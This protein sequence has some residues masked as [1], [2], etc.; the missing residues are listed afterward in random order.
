[1]STQLLDCDVI[2]IGGGVV[3]LTLAALLAQVPE[4]RVKVFDRGRVP[5]DEEKSHYDRRVS[6]INHASITIFQS[7]GIWQD[8]VA[9]RSNPYQKIQVWDAN[10]SARIHFDCLDVGQAFLGHIVEHRVMQQVLW[11]HLSQLSQVQLVE[12]ASVTDLQP[13]VD[14]ISVC[15]ND[16]YY[17]ATLLIGADGGD[18]WVARQ[19]SFTIKTQPYQQSALVTTVALTDSHQHTAWQRFLT[20]GP[21]AFLPLADPHLASIVWSTTPDQA[22]YLEQEKEAAF[23]QALEDAIENTFGSLQAIDQRM[24]FPLIQRHAQRYVQSRIALVGDAAHTI[25]PLAGQGI[26]LGLMDAAYLAQIVQNTWLA[27]R[28]IGGLMNLRRYERSRKSDN[29]MMLA[30]MSGF[31]HVFGQQQI[32][33]RQ[34]RQWGFALTEKLPWLKAQWMKRAMGLSGDLPERATFHW[35]I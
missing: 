1:M 23:N 12:S 27:Q 2:I 7:L 10:S 21:L 31:K 33:Y 6:A 9:W 29:L 32:L 5:L 24:V 26:N 4:L 25:H 3:G 11:R 18:S 22:N 14:R 35:R 13:G 28:D 20:T 34:A 17:H 19:A 8:I 15:A 30:A 16:T